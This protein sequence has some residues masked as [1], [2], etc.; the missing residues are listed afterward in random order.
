MENKGISVSFLKNLLY[1]MGIVIVILAFLFFRMRKENKDTIQKLQEYSSFIESKRDSLETE[2]KG[3][4]IQYDSLKTNNDTLNLKLELQQDKI[5]KLLAL[6]IGDAEKIRKYEKELVT[7]REVLRSYI[8]QIDSLNTKNQLL[9]V[10]NKELRNSSLKLENENKQ[11]TEEKEELITIKEEAKTLIAS[12]IAVVPLNKRNKENDK[13]DKT[14]KIRTDFTLRKNTVADAG[15][16][17]IYLRLIRP[18][19]VVLGS[20]KSGGVFEFETQQIPF[21]ASREVNYE[22]NDLPVSIFWEN[23]G[24]LVKGNY[25]CELFCENKLIGAGAFILK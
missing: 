9:L 7:I 25:K 21:S 3:I 15:A 12:G 2:L 11:L 20:P 4:I 19:G 18:D 23:N 22:K 16:K 8:V 14:E 10:E 17:I 5:K 6:R 13:V 24:D 1:I